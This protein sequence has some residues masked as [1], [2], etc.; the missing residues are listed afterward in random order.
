MVTYCKV[1]LQNFQK[2]VE[3]LNHRNGTRHNLT[4]KLLRFICADV[5][6]QPN[7]F[8][9]HPIKNRSNHCSVLQIRI[10]PI[11]K[12]RSVALIA[13]IINQPKRARNPC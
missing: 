5:V 2:T 4:Y 11:S 12:M 1:W 3:I 6:I 9:E 8:S 13:N 10:N 7:K